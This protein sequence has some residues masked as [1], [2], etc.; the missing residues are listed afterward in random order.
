MQAIIKT[1]GTQVKVAKGKK[2][3]VNLLSAAV[4]D[5]V[6]FETLAVYGDTVKIGQPIVA[7]AKVQAKVLEHTRGEKI[8]VRTYKRRKGFHKSRGHRQELTVLEVTNIV[9]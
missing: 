7:G 6:D 9:A 8:Y 3:E 2:F 4:G 1:G 5:T